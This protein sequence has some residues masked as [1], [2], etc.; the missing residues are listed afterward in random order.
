MAF[1]SSSNWGSEIFPAQKFSQA[2]FSSRRLQ[3][4][5]R[6]LTKSKYRKNYGPHNSSTGKLTDTA[7]SRKRRQSNDGRS[8]GLCHFYHPSHPKDQDSGYLFDKN[9]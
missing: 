3:N 8:P 6:T 5:T 4:F 1:A 7:F 9:Y 2:F